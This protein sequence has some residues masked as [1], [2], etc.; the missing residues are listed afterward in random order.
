MVEVL[1]D[2][3]RTVKRDLTVRTIGR[4][5]CRS[6]GR[7][8]KATFHAQRWEASEAEGRVWGRILIEGVAL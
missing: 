7:L 8:E 5:P 1:D 4:P 2:S 6:H 3:R